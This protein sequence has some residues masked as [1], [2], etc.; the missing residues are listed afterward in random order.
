MLSI[1]KT[2][3]WI[4]LQSL[5]F[6]AVAQDAEP[7]RPQFHFSP[8]ANWTNDPNGL[9]FKDGVYH[10]YFQYYP[11][12]TKWGP[13]HW[14]HATSK[15]LVNWTEQKI[16]LYPDSLGYIFSG[17]TVID[18]NNTSGFGKNG[19]APVIAIFTYH[20]PVGEKARKNNYQTQGIAYSFDNGHTW[21]KYSGN[22]VLHNPGI[23]DFRDP[24]VSWHEQDKK[25]VMTLATKDRITFFSSPDLKSWTKLSEF[26]ERTGAHGGVWE[27]PDLFPLSYQGKNVW[28]LLVS[29]NPG[30]PNGGSATQYFLGDFDGKNF[31]PYDSVERWIDHGTDNYAG[32]TFFNTGN[33]RLFMGWMNNWQYGDRVPT[34]KWRGAMTLP[35]ELNLKQVNGKFYLASTPV[36]EL[37]GITNKT[38]VKKVTDLVGSYSTPTTGIFKLDL[39]GIVTNNYSIILSNEK[40]S[41]LMIGFDKQKNQYYIDRTR[42]GIVNFEQGFAKRQWAPRIA[43]GDR[44]QLTLVV[45]KASVELFAD[46]GLTVMTAVFFPESPVSVVR[47]QTADNSIIKRLIY[48]PLKENNR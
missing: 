34:V 29:I 5:F 3:A 48:I 25:W 15:D 22:P 42:S 39:E 47:V 14:G 30:G 23:V 36:K 10:L 6:S 33:R 17:S 46:D 28:V 1:K 12:D 13:M 32:V 26:G 43:T 19:R 7:F 41:E 27:C 16:A 2:F 45:D 31:I 40:G 18:K 24:K 9:F 21:T 11:N 38:G 20:D 37:D 8:N 4:L 35:R 44:A